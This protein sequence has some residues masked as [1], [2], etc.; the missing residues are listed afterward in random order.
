M[1]SLID[2]LYSGGELSNE[3]LFSL[4]DR[5]TPELAEYLF[6]KSREI[7]QKSFGRKIFLRGLI[8]ISSYCKNDC[9]YCGIRKS[10]QNAERYLLDKE[11]VLSCCENGYQLGF[12]SFVLQ[13]GENGGISDEMLIEIIS[14][15]RTKYSDCAITLSVGEKPKKTYQKFFDAGA[16]RYLLRHETANEEH[17]ARLHPSS[18]SLKNRKQCLFDL[19]EIG[20]QTG[21]GFMVGSPFQTTQNLVEDIMFMKEL[22]PEMIGIG[23]FVPHHDTPFKDFPAGTAELTLFLIGILRLMF[24]KALI[25]ATTSLGT[26]DG[27]GREN[28]ILAGANVLMPNLSPVSVR[29]KYL[30]YDN[31][32]CTGEEAAE[33]AKCLERRISSIGYEIVSDR[34][35][36]KV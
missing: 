16:N 35:D 33:C 23:P 20:F 27:K 9:L 28:G 15:I 19:K 10:N 18:M 30:L 21:T 17:Y 14:E 12:R 13:G 25:P 29:K 34:G 31:K 22:S 7:S 4:I 24:P 3:E 11:T 32:I 36:F 2:K 5:R 6:E 8:E 1:K 26:V